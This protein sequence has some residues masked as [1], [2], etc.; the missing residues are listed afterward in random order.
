MISGLY[1]VNSCH[2]SKTMQLDQFLSKLNTTPENVAFEDTMAVIEAN[3]EYQACAFINGSAENSAEQNQGSCK[4]LAFAQ[5]QGL[6]QTKTL[7]C[8]GQY[9]RNDVLGNPDGE[10]HQNIRQFMTNG[11]DGVSFS[12]TPLSSKQASK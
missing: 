6:D 11:W 2:R 10:D 5:L 7:A 1:T 12:G 4:L 3:Y 9:Y 8:F